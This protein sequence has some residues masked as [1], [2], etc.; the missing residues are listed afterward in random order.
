MKTTMTAV[1]AATFAGCFPSQYES[2]DPVEA[3]YERERR[4]ATWAMLGCSGDAVCELR[5]EMRKQHAEHMLM[6][7]R[8]ELAAENQA[9]APSP[10]EA[11]EWHCFN[12]KSLGFG[13]CSHSDESCEAGLTAAFGT[14]EAIDTYCTAQSTAYCFGKKADKGYEEWC[15]PTAEACE[16]AR[17]NSGS[18]TS[19]ACYGPQ[20]P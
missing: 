19:A 8:Q 6:L 5:V 3:Q 15:S 9:S 11:D 10:R 1:I 18:D 16:I 2:T 12:S 20:S 13:L 7:R 4:A 14:V 17:S